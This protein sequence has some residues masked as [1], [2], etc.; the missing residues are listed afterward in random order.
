M[1]FNIKQWQIEIGVRCGQ[2]GN[3]AN[4]RLCWD[5]KDKFYMMYI[6]GWRFGIRENPF[7]FLEE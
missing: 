6:L 1:E 4:W 5:A 3:R 2:P 7:Y